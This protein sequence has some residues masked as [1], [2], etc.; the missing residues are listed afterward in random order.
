MTDSM[1]EKHKAILAKLWVVNLTEVDRFSQ[2]KLALDAM[3]AAAT[4]AREE[5]LE[6]AAAICDNE[7][8]AAS[9]AQRI[10]SLK[11][12]PAGREKDN[13]QNPDD[14]WKV[15]AGPTPTPTNHNSWE[16]EPVTSWEFVEFLHAMGWH[17]S[18]KHFRLMAE[19][20]AESRA[21]K[22]KQT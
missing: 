11:S 16:T 12:T 19:Q 21:A 8:I 18:A 7:M 9:A 5:A 4:Q 1:R 17:S 15:E 14:T 20:R 10:R 2:G 13:G 22:E 3:S 6:E